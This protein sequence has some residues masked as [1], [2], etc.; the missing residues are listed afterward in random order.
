M[1]SVPSATSCHRSS[2]ERTPPGNRQAM[3]MTAMGSLSRASTDS[4]RC[5]VRRRSVV[6]FLR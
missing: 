5:R 3:P 6:T 4:S 1:A 2:G